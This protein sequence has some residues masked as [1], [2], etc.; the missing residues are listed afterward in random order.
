MTQLNTVRLPSG[1]IIPALG[2]GTWHMGEKKAARRFRR[3]KTERIDL[4][5]LHWRGSYPLADTQDSA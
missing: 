1:R 2:L 4:Y 5:L 3:L